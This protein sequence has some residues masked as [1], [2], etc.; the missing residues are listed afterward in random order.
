MVWGMF[1]GKGRGGTNQG[2]LER[3]GRE[4]K[5]EERHVNISPH[6]SQLKPL[7]IALLRSSPPPFPSL[8]SVIHSSL[9]S[10][11][12]TFFPFPLHIGIEC[13]VTVEKYTVEYVIQCDE[14]ETMHH[15]VLLPFQFSGF[16]YQTSCSSRCRQ[17]FFVF[18]ANKCMNVNY[19]KVLSDALAANFP[20]LTTK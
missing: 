19:K 5:R 17:C 20:N 10:F 15:M 9:P 6:Q 13:G 2:R 12:F 16:S 4:G 11:S 14:A 7:R 3:G 1:W 8:L 18:F